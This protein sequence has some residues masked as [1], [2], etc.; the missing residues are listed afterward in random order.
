MRRFLLLLT[1]LC[2]IHTSKSQNLSFSCPQDTL[3]G[4]NASC[5]TITG[6][7]PDIRSLASDY[8]FQNV[9]AASAC[10]PF[11]DPGGPG[12]SANLTIDDKYS[13]VLT[14]PF[15][16]PFYG[17][18]YNSVV[19]STNGYISFDVSLATQFSHY[20]ILNSGGFLSATSGQSYP[21][22]DLPSSLYD[23]ALI[24]GP[25]HDLDPAYTTSPTQ[26]I[27][28]ETFG[29]APNR[30][31]ILSFYKVPL[32]TNS[33][34]GCDLLI[35]NTH[36]IILYESTGVVEVFVKDQQIC[37]GWNDGKSMIGMQNENATKG[38]MAPGR[39]AS[40]PAWGSIG[41]NETWRFI[42]KDGPTLYRKVELLDG[43]GA[44][45][46]VGDTT[47]IDANTFETSFPNICPSSG[48]SVYVIKTTYQKIDDPTPGAT[49][50][51]LDTINVI[52]TPAMPMDTVVVPTACAQT[53]GAITVYANAGTPPYTFTLSGP[54]GPYA[55]QVTN[56]NSYT[57]TNLGAGAY[58]VGATESAGCTGTLNVN[59]PNIPNLTATTTTT[60]GSCPGVNDATLTITP[61][62]GATAGPYNYTLT[63]PGGPYTQNNVTSAATFTGLAG[64][65]YSVT[66]VNSA[67]CS[68]SIAT[69]V[70]SPGVTPSATLTSNS[71][72]CN[73]A[74]DGT[75]TITFTASS[76]AGPYN[77]T[78]NPGGFAQSGVVGSVTFSGLT[79]QT[80]TY[81]FT[82]AAGCVKTGTKTVFT[83]STPTADIVGTDASCPGVNNGTITITPLGGAAQ[84][85]YTITLN[86]GA[87]VQTG[88]ATAAT[89]TGLA[90]A[91]YSATFTNAAGCNGTSSTWS[92]ASGNPIFAGTSSSPTSCNGAL[93]GT[94]TITP[95]GG[96]AQGPYTITLNPGGIVHSGVAAATIFTGLAAGPY[97]A[98]FQNA[99][100]C[101]GTTGTVTVGVGASLTGT[102]IPTATSCPTRNDG[103]ITVTPGGVG[104]YTVTLSGGG[105]TLPIIQSGVAATATFTGL[106]PGTYTVNF[107]TAS[108][109]N[110]IVNPNPVVAA[111]P[112][113]SSS[114]TQQ[115]PVCA[116][117]NDG[118]ITITNPG[119]VAPYT[120]V[121]TGPGGPYTQANNPLFT[122]LAP[123]TY[124]YD[125]TDNVGCTG[126]GGPIVLTTNS[127][128]GVNIVMTEPLCHGDANGKIV[129]TAS[130][131]VNPYQ[132]ALSP[133]TTYQG[134]TFTG[135]ITGTYTFRIKDNVGCTK[136]T[137]VTLGEPT[138][139]TAAAN[140][141]APA[142]CFGND[143]TIVVTG[144]GG[145]P[146]YT[147]SI[148]G[149]NFQ[150]SNTFV[151]PAVG[152]YPN[153]KVK[154]ANGCIASASTTVSLVDAMFL[155]LGPDT[156]ICVGKSVKM[157]PQTNPG[158]SVWAWRPLYPLIT[159]TSTIDTINIR[160]ATVTPTD[161][162]I[163]VL[164]AHWG[165]CVRED[166]IVVNVLHKPVANA[167]LDTAICNLSYAILRGSATN[168]SGTV[169]YS[170]T[171]AADITS[172]T[173]AVTTVYPPGADVTHT[174]TLTVTDNYGCNFSV[175]DDVD[176]H[177][178]PP[179][180]AFAGRDTIA[181]LNSPHQLMGSGGVEYLWSPAAPLN[182]A[183]AQNP[184]AT[185]NHDQLFVLKVTDIAGCIGYDSVFVQVFEGPNYHVPNAFTPNGDGLNDVFRAIPPG[186]AQ[187]EYIRIF[188]RYGQLVFETHEWMKG[189][190][191]R[192]QGK[193]QPQGAYVWII[194][195]VDKNGRIIEKKGTVMLL[196]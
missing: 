160:T 12:P 19:V 20:G 60:A 171:P 158:T 56:S 35:D 30:K 192:Y 25:Y 133:F 190:D 129:L 95:A 48:A 188:N 141:P 157:L 27:K 117:I 130:G 176:V 13:T 174:Y 88:V 166:T 163:Y 187:T 184:L 169:N 173:D 44:V 178:Q 98:T 64:G 111:G 61:D 6:R 114:F 39:K 59:V 85:P 136:D 73:G 67:G 31:W 40:D 54:G 122:N 68:G 50:Y 179:V 86:P 87:I 113:L 8:S 189:W 24:M 180:P 144:L 89:F 168:L 105:L 11:V 172:P 143:G 36:Q 75:I 155:T 175:S 10:R 66:F 57:W 7:F 194:K 55:P 23:N 147:Y 121:L 140:S 150:S 161:T 79:A 58:V 38:I 108:G 167:G 109:C 153:I 137:T 119:G 82:N 74:A 46:A 53:T 134:G 118:T 1:L 126:T 102:A 62:L 93:D 22:E 127:P 33:G 97:T 116:N 3:L 162:A 123:G 128:I 65:T 104:P 43:T 125:F 152:P 15:N 145:T 124:N 77:V 9:S 45:V 18:T 112:F 159:P 26:Q 181:V 70:V 131:G 185:L 80:Y 146:A 91:I 2:C 16:F 191:G 165:T 47:R 32:F 139:L 182:L 196:P 177:V 5:L 72:S 37:P 17:T 83:G 183:S 110:G 107:S 193:L 28:Y 63:G 92:I 135:L 69:I 138:L 81:S 14:L 100:G 34:G 51:S 99:A 76:G 154:D 21:G 115:N 96:A 103:T 94:V 84:G 170:W 120:F 142:S 101:S 195:G 132:Y 49:I 90:P 148:N 156:T 41:M 42:P 4:C 186:I 78:L 164:Q 151:A 52:K 106:A 149:T 29:T 71:T